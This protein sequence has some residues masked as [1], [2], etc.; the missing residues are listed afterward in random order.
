MPTRLARAAR[1][2]LRI[3]I[4]L[5]LLATA[6]GK[7]LDVP[8]F[9]RVLESYQAFPPGSIPWIAWAVPLA[10]LGL[11]VW[12][13]S[14]YRLRAAAVGST[15]THLLYAFWSAV[16]LLGGLRLANCGCFGVFLERPLTWGTV[17]EDSVMVALSAALAVLAGR[18]R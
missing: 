3:A 4:G 11:A 16:S 12:L 14:A 18:T 2:S 6:A 7:L 9:A 8:G 13:F 5:V 17:W 15:L 10:E 1:E